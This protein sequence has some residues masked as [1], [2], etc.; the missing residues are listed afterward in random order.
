MGDVHEQE[1][2]TRRQVMPAGRQV[3]KFTFYRVDPAWRRLP[4]REREE[5]KRHLC[6]VV[7]AFDDRL[8]IRSYSLMGMRGDADLLLWQTGDRLEDIQELATAVLST[9]MGPYLSV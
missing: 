8:L 3:V 9:A 6:D 7:Q 4:P 5:A 2:H 1:A